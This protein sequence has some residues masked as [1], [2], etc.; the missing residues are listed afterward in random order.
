MS[1]RLF[2][3][4]VQNMLTLYPLVALTFFI[5]SKWSENFG[6]VLFYYV[7]FFGVLGICGLLILSKVVRDAVAKNQRIKTKGHLRYI[8]LSS[9]TVIVI[10]LFFG[11]VFTALMWLISL[12]L[13][14]AYEYELRKAYGEVI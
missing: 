14:M 9:L 5:P 7:L 6:N 13:V 3:H 12:I 4:I 1:K 11:W 10:F 2:K 8:L